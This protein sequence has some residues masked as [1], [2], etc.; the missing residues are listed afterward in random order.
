MR[1]RRG[2][3]CFVIKARRRWR[4]N[5]TDVGRTKTIRRGLLSFGLR[6]IIKGYQVI[7]FNEDDKRIKR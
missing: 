2:K 5:A 1:D 6:N 7:R 4:N 3:R